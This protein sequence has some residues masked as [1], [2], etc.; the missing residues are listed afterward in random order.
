MHPS[1]PSRF[2]FV[3]LCG[4][5]TCAR[6]LPGPVRFCPYCGTKVDVT[7]V[8]EGSPPV[9]LQQ[10]HSTVVPGQRSELHNS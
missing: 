2:S 7:N 8:V 3:A 1:E 6:M 5:E 10:T 4:H 9:E